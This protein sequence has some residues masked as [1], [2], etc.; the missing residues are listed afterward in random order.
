MA[1]NVLGVLFQDIADAI[2][3]KTGESGKIVPL[4]FPNEINSIVVGSGGGSG[5]ETGLGDLKITTGSFS[6]GATDVYQRTI[7]HGH[8]KMP[9]MIMV[10][11]S[12]SL[13]PN[14]EVADHVSKQAIY[15]AVGVNSSLKDVTSFKGYTIKL[16]SLNLQSDY[17]MDEDSGS[18]Y[19]GWYNIHCPDEDTFIL[20][21]PST[22]TTTN[23]L[24]GANTNYAW[25][26][27]SGMG[28]VI[29]SGSADERVKY[30]TFMNGT[31]EL[32]KQPVIS[33][34]TC[35]DPVLNGYIDACT[36]E[37]TAQ[38]TYSQTGW[39]FTDSGSADDNALT[40]VTEDRIVYPAF[41]ATTRKYTIT[42]L[43]DDGVTVLNTEQLAYGTVPSYSPTKDDFAFDKWTPTPVA[44]TCD[45]SYT[46]SWI[47]GIGGTLTDTVRWAFSE[48][49]G[50]LTI[51]GTGAMPTFTGVA[52][53]PWWMNYRE[54]ITKIVVEEGITALSQYS[55]TN[56][57]ATE[58]SLPSTLQG[59]I[60]VQCFGS[61]K[62]LIS[63]VIPE[64]IT[65]LAG[66]AFNGASG[67]KSVN[68]PQSLVTIKG[69][70]FRDCTSL[71]EITIPQNVNYIGASAFT[72]SSTTKMKLAKAYFENTTGWWV[73]DT[74][75]ATSGT[76]IDISD[77]STAATHLTN[78]YKAKHWHRT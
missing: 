16:N 60:P 35:R 65:L 49:T 17:Y 41:K 27:I 23:G 36:K 66:S 42:W 43:D 22:S 47:A 5:T 72:T 76:A 21:T 70:V 74:A 71:T 78:T 13:N 45:V 2:R 58:V 50:V 14:G 15:F 63:I 48:E 53:V 51:R 37:S 24:F 54:S 55:F 39:S 59:E 19:L 40:N 6:T 9:D 46:A 20:G 18:S 34:D 26:A 31:T 61:C 44:V 57:T 69:G 12:D 3:N 52:N 77:A 33:G 4:D 68:L 7:N 8:G 30:V 28:G 29:G 73:A 67:L 10:W 62:N 11:N 1:D 25:M 64:G 32:Y 56:N 38:Y 75:D